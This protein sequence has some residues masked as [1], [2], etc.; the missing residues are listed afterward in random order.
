MDLEEESKEESHMKKVK[1]DDQ[2]ESS[3]STS[4]EESSLLLA[5][6][7]QVFENSLV[8]L[9]GDLFSNLNIHGKS[10]YLYSDYTYMYEIYMVSHICHLN[11]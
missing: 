11:C 5:L 1:S 6:F 3:G 4:E 2:V 7:R 10:V 9:L 8:S